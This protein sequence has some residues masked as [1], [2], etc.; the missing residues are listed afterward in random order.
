MIV[1]FWIDI[2]N[3]LKIDFFVIIFLFN[4]FILPWGSNRL[5]VEKTEKGDGKKPESK[6]N[7]TEASTSETLVAAEVD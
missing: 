5:I 7:A 3:F 1:K 2:F 4:D 6:S